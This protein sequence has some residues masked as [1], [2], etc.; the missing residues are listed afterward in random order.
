MRKKN[1]KK[2]VLKINI[3]LLL[4]VIIGLII[5][6]SAVKGYQVIK[7]KVETNVSNA[8]TETTNTRYFSLQEDETEEEDTSKYSR[9]YQEYLKLSDEE[10]AN[11]SVIPRKYTVSLD[12]L[13]EDE[14]EEDDVSL[15]SSSVTSSTELADSFDLRDEIEIDTKDQGDLGLCYAFASLRSVQTNLLLNGYENYDF[16]ELHFAFMAFDGFSGESYTDGGNFWYFEDAYLGGG[17][18]PVLEEDMPYDSEYT[19]DDYDDI[20]DLDPAVY[21]TE[22]VD[23]P[24]IDKVNETYTDEE[25]EL[26]RDTVKQ[27]IT[28]NGSVYASIDAYYDDAYTYTIEE[29]N[30]YYTL[31]TDFAFSDVDHAVSIIGWDDNFSKDN[32]KSAYTTSSPDNDGAWIA[33]NS[34]GEEYEIIYISYEDLFVEQEMSGVVSVTLDV[35]EASKEIQFEDENLYNLLKNDALK[36]GVISY[37]DE[38]LTLTCINSNVIKELNFS[39]QSISSLTGIENFENLEYLYLGNNNITDISNLSTLTNLSLL[40]LYMNQIED[41]S[42]LSNLTNLWY[43]DI[44]YNEISDLSFLENLDSLGLFFL[45]YNNITDISDLEFLIDNEN[46]IYY[47]DYYG[48]PVDILSGNP[49]TEGFEIISDIDT[50]T[51]YLNECELDDSIIETLSNLDLDGL[52]Y[53]LLEYNDITDVSNLNIDGLSYLDLSGNQNLDTSTIKYEG[54]EGLY[55]NDCN[56]S[57]ISFLKDFTGYELSLDYNPIED[58]SI[59]TEI[60]SLEYLY[61][62]DTGITD[63]SCLDDEDTCIYY[64]DLSENENLTGLE[65]LPSTIVTLILEDCNLEDISFLTNNSNYENVYE[66][67]L[68]NNNI[69]DISP[70]AYLSN[71]D[72]LSLESNLIEEIPDLTNLEALTIL[73]LNYNNIQMVDDTNLPSSLISLEVKGN[74]LTEFSR[75][76]THEY[77]VDLS[78]NYISEV[79]VDGYGTYDMQSQQI[80]ITYSDESIN[81]FDMPSILVDAYETR[82]KNY[83][84][85]YIALYNSYNGYEEQ[86]TFNLEGCSLDFDTG[87]VTLESTEDVATISID[88]GIYDGSSITISYSE[89]VELVSISVETAPTKTSYTE[90]ET[91]DTTGMTVIATYS[92]GSTQEITDYEISPSEALTTSDTYVTISYTE[93]GVTAT[94]TQEI[95]VTASSEDDNNSSDDTSNSTDTDNTTTNDTTTNDTTDNTSSNSRNS[96]TNS[97]SSNNSSNSSS[98]TSSSNTNST[99]ATSSLPYTGVKTIIIG[100]IAVLGVI[101]I[102]IHKKWNDLDGI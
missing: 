100:I 39:N 27:H 55:L 93:N 46:Y 89:S 48:L 33:I 11:L 54:L 80:N 66:L 8:N 53:L 22:T 20:Y 31:Y 92:D 3:S 57:D 95:T 7:V 6:I 9:A 45:E 90:G 99:T 77:Y 18:G 43:L 25:L 52:E 73:N 81:T 70:I 42:E 85:D 59:L 102:V 91:F 44:A 49:I 88:G 101:T 50:S 14:T 13:Y 56:L 58:I 72:Y 94:T 68:D 75:S 84:L 28:E 32:F 2:K 40:I 61:L 51:L 86:T 1:A 41:A 21:V 96:T 71:L 67:Y 26:F 98:S 79:E 23:F 63:V 69:T 19:E 78:E 30:G 82:Y 24:T 5:L 87:I 64:L 15:S 74:L 62:K 37:D 97:N 38:N 36:K 10:K 60:E 29:I 12:M 34:W 83:Y 16:S 4:S 35:N 47:S 17:Y 76:T 65:D